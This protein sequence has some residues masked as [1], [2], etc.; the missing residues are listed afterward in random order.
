[1]S[2]LAAMDGSVSLVIVVHQQSMLVAPCDRGGGPGA[3]FNCNLVARRLLQT[4]SPIPLYRYNFAIL[5][6]CGLWQTEARRHQ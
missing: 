1:M 5:R 3:S 6:F 4:P 2:V